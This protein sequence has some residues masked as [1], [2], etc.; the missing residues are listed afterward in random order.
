MNLCFI[1]NKKICWFFFPS[2]NDK[3]MTVLIEDKTASGAGSF[4]VLY[5]E[6]YH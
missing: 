4:V 6:F 2:S 1:L 3:I 5:L